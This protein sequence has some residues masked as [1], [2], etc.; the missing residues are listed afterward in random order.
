M[1]KTTI[2]LLL[3]LF[4]VV[5]VVFGSFEVEITAADSIYANETAVYH[6]KVNNTGRSDE[7]I[8][9]DFAFD[10]KWSF[11]TDPL[12]YL[13]QFTLLPGEET[14]FDIILVPTSPLLS[15]GKYAFSIPFVT[16]TTEE[17]VDVILH[18]KNPDALTG[19]VPSLSFVLD[20][21]ELVDPRQTSKVKL[22]VRNRNPLDISEMVVHLDSDLYSDTQIVPIESLGATTVVFEIDYDPQQVPVDDVLLLTVSVG[23]TSFAPIRKEIEIISYEDIVEYQKPSSSLFFKTETVTEYTNNGNVDVVEEFKYAVSGIGSFFTSTD[24]KGSVVE[25]E[26]L[27]YYVTS[28]EI[29]L[30]ETV[31][32]VHTISYR[33]LALLVLLAGL[34][35]LLYYKHRSPVVVSKE[36]VTL[37]VDKDGRM[38][39]KVLIHLKNRGS[40]LVED[41]D[42]RD[43]IPAVAEIEK[44]FE[45]GTL[46]PT[47]I[48]KHQ[49]AGTLL[50]WS[51]HH[52]EAYEERI[53]T[54]KVKSMYAIVGNLYLPSTTARFKD[55]KGVRKIGSNKPKV[56]V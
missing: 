55:K 30:G 35:V 13:S 45:M 51:I 5:P 25:D 41:V 1:R 42:V 14:E 10:I 54:Y 2:L 52:L 4:L 24:P 34:G 12:T 15:S 16:D 3:T 40:R 27:L 50:V 37:D 36:T 22:E 7:T 44:H 33:P 31:T 23:E 29:P 26:G 21:V 19:Y 53:I 28:V 9:T 46:K 39:I 8:T 6:V 18:I 38:K 17:V 43:K 20:A 32:I 56:K 47:K 48:L 49:K 11:E